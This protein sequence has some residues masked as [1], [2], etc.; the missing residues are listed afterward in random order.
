MLGKRVENPCVWAQH[1]K[2]QCVVSVTWN[3]NAVSKV[4]TVLFLDIQSAQ[5]EGHLPADARQHIA[6]SSTGIGDVWGILLLSCSF[7]CEEGKGEQAFLLLS[8]RISL[9]MKRPTGSRLRAPAAKWTK[10]QKVNQEK[11]VMFEHEQ[12]AGNWALVNIRRVHDEMRQE[13]GQF[14]DQG[15][16]PGGLIGGVS[17]AS[18]DHGAHTFSNAYS[19][20]DWGMADWLAGCKT[21]RKCAT[22][23]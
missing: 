23:Y 12:T 20:S 10:V 16:N 5:S 3:Y 14:R 11:Y 8:T 2:P 9:S 13:Q 1:Y 7:Q 4:M 18:K 15:I 6:R 17:Y 19:W 21:L 22:G